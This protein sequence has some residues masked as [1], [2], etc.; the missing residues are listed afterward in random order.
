[1]LDEVLTAGEWPE[2]LC[3]GRGGGHLYE[4][5]R[6]IAPLHR[7]DIFLCEPGHGLLELVVELL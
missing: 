4:I 1:M 6:L 5:E 7:E 2:V 3:L